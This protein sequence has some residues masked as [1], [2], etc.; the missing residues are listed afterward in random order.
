[1]I[2][3][4]TLLT[5]K[6]NPDDFQGLL[7]QLFLILRNKFFLSV[8]FPQKQEIASVGNLEFVLRTFF[9]LGIPHHARMNSH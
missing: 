8:W 5:E 7:L 3:K 2:L 4:T 6:K 1:M 9:G